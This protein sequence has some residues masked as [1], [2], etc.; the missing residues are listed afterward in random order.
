MQ[1][2][3]KFLTLF[4]LVVIAMCFISENSLSRSLKAVTWA[5]IRTEIANYICI[6]LNIQP[7][8][9][10]FP[11]FNLGDSYRCSPDE[12]NSGKLASSVHQVLEKSGPLL[13]G[14]EPHH[15]EVS[16][17]ANISLEEQNIA[18]QEK[19]LSS[20][21]FLRP[22]LNRMERALWSQG[23]KCD[24][25]PQL[26][27]KPERLVSWGEFSEYLAAYAWPDP[28][29]TLTDSNGNPFGKT[30][31]QI[32]ICV[33]INGISELI[34]NPDED[35]VYSAFVIAFQEKFIDRA[36]IQFGE[37][38]EEKEFKQITNDSLRTEYLRRR[39]PERIIQDGKIQ[40][41]AA[42]KLK[43]Y[44]NDLRIRMN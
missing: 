41:Y 43:E 7:N 42:A 14:I 2:N 34:E 5:D 16:Y 18:L 27:V 25:L 9:D 23:L 8:G 24:D 30:H 19:L 13:G 29:H 28:V 26:A 3:R 40:R 38:L 31:Y 44:F 4:T 21:M 39:L 11:R 20:E 22:V 15:L 32:H 1:L 35:L 10:T 17:D 36:F 37:T 6:E 33:G 12:N